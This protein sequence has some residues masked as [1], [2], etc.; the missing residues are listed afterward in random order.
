MGILRQD[1]VY[2]LRSFLKN[3]G[4]TLIAIAALAL[5]IGANS[6]IFTVVNAV[7]LRPLPYP[8][9]DRLVMLWQ[10]N[11]RQGWMRAGVSG[12]TY[13]DWVEQARLFEEISLHEQGSGTLTGLGEPEQIPGMR[14]TTNFF[15]LLGARAQLGRLFTAEESKGGRHN[16]AVATHGF[17]Q[18]RLGGSPNALGRQ[19]QV[20]GLT[21]TLI[22]VLTPDFWLPVPSEVFVPWPAEELRGMNRFAQSF[23]VLGRL[24]PGVTIAL[25]NQELNAIE[26]RIAEKTPGYQD[27]SA[28]VV[29]LKEV[30]VG[31]IRPAL[32]VLLGAVGF[33]LLIACANVA[34]LL[35]A[36][37]TGRRKEIAIR[38]AIGAGRGRLVRQLLTESALLGLIGGSLG[39]LLAMWGTSLL[40]AVL[41]KHVRVEESAG[42]VALA[43]ISVDS[44]VLLF[45]LAVSLFTGFIF[46]LAPALAASRAAASEALKETSRGSAGTSHARMRDALVVCE[47][48]LALVLLIGAG[49]MIRS[50]RSLQFVQPGFQPGRVIALEMELPTDSKYRR[51]EEWAP[52][53]QRFLERVQALPGVQSAGLTDIVPLTVYEDKVAFDIERRAGAPGERRSADDRSVSPEYFQ[54]LGIPLLQGRNLSPL[55]HR[56]APCATVVDQVFVR[57]N[58]PNENPIARRL[59]LQLGRRTVPCEIVGVVGA[60]RA[61][62]IDK[63]PQ[64]TVYFSYWQS[65]ANRMSL[66]VRTAGDPAGFVNSIKQAVWSVDPDQPLYNIRTIDALIA[67]SNSGSRFVL[68]LLGLFSALA[69]ALASIGIYGVMSYSVSQRRQE[70][71]IRM[72]L[73]AGRA[74]VLRMIVRRAMMLAG[75]G[76]GAGLIAAFGLT[77]ALSVLLYGVTPT[78]PATFAS[79]GLLTFAVA[80]GASYLPARRAMRVDPVTALRYE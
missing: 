32:L 36:R 61:A 65:P 42:M 79:V 62:G 73:G 51:R 49:L 58:F 37:A 78:D 70:I 30:L 9:S 2:A 76:V 64:P 38:A 63:Q 41:P 71:G 55:D 17:W 22:G 57:Q 5:G 18:R 59:N 48:A 53:F 50:F 72:A 34:N 35:L 68:T 23:T 21:Y 54:T 60:V 3:P 28:L 80:A 52:I 14:V 43:N 26:R 16:V 56:D 40:A 75:L 20:D 33:V 69:V 6:A 1:V 66:V 12:A 4:F 7:L 44:R 45:T 10:Q 13:V 46:G 15:T 29:P 19:Y 39:L 31:A 67:E 25:A 24:K 11:L 47:V 74:D 77:R 8:N 27:W